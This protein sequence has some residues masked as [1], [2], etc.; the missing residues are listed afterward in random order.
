V[1]RELHD[2]PASI[3]RGQLPPTPLAWPQGCVARRPLGDHIVIELVWDADRVGTGTSSTGAS[4]ATGDA[5]A[6]EPG[7]LAALATASCLMRTFLRLA[8]AG[9]V[10]VLGFVAAAHMR[11][12][13]AAPPLLHLHACVVVAAQGSRSAAVELL[14]RARQASPLARMLGDGLIMDVDVCGVPLTCEA[15]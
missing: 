15:T 8:E 14:A 3:N 4:L 6:W 13:G 12:G 5:A 7:E 1:V 11:A 10:P 2:L 9:G